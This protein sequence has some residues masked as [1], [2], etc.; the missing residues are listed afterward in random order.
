MEEDF[1]QRGWKIELQAPQGVSLACIYQKPQNITNKPCHDA[2]GPYTNVLDLSLFPM[3][4]KR[5]SEKLQIWNSTEASVDRIWE[6]VKEVWASTS[7]ASVARS[8][9]HA[10]RVM[11][12]IIQEDGNNAWLA[13]GTPHCGVR[14]DFI[15]TNDG[16]RRKYPIEV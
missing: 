6:T 13:E 1:Q 5:H 8:F 7:S 4:S 2:T 14:H 15:D 16:I 10:Y 12:L 3:M 11:K 9:V